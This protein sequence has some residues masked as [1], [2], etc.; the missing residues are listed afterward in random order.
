MCSPLS[1]GADGTEWSALS[2]RPRGEMTNGVKS[3]NSSTCSK[4]LNSQPANCSHTLDSGSSACDCCLH[5]NPIRGFVK[6]DTVCSRLQRLA[7]H[8]CIEKWTNS[9]HRLDC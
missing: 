2:S 3:R 9:I 7:T 4:H 6:I 1:L 5:A 8:L